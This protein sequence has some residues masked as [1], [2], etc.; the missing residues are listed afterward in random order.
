M[1]LQQINTPN[2]V[3]YDYDESWDATITGNPPNF[4]ATLIDVRSNADLNLAVVGFDI[5]KIT[6]NGT[7]DVTEEYSDYILNKEWTLWQWWPQPSTSVVYDPNDPDASWKDVFDD[8]NSINDMFTLDKENNYL[9]YNDQVT[10]NFAI[11]LRINVSEDFP[12][13]KYELK[14]YI[15]VFPTVT[16]PSG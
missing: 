3:V 12:A 16:L 8:E 9:G 14:F 5:I 7:S 13:G 15:Y 6:A 4:V 11:G 10:A 2:L 1:E